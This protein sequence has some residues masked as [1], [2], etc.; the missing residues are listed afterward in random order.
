M[1]YKINEKYDRIFTALSMDPNLDKDD[2]KE[3]NE[4]AVVEFLQTISILNMGSK[5]RGFVFGRQ[6]CKMSWSC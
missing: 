3:S 1:V 6:R 4:K 5:N 2:K